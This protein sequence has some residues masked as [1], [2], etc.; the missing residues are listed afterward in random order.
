MSQ[1]VLDCSQRGYPYGNLVFVSGNNGASPVT[2]FGKMVLRER[3]AR[4][5]SVHELAKRTGVAAGHLSR[6]ENGLRPPTERVALACDAAFGVTAFTEFYEDSKSWAP[7]G[8]RDWAEYEDKA[9]ALRA[10]SPGVLHG[11]VQTE[12]YAR[13][14][15]ETSG[16]AGE[17]VATRL[18]SRMERQRRLFARAN[19]PSVWF[20]V[21]E[22]SLYRCVGSAEIMAAQMAHLAGVA[23]MPNVTVQILGGIAHP[24]GASGFIVT[25]EAAYAEHVAGGYVF[26]DQETVTGLERLFHMIHAECNRASESLRM[27]ERL[28]QTWTHGGS[29][30]TPT[31]MAATV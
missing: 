16:A 6:I 27:I 2:Y 7:P 25:S 28:G 23:G 17:V 19:P 22:L 8:F 21:D 30:L 3:K 29:P 15:L 31:P 10:W 24:A 12:D 1:I 18:T 14:L 4:G 5:W 26:T 9:V 20:V 11:L 13:A